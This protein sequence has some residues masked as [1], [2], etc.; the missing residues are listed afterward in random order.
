MKVYTVV[1]CLLCLSMFSMTSELYA[2]GRSDDG[3]DSLE[4]RGVIQ[5]KG[6]WSFSLH[7]RMSKSSFWVEMG[8]SLRGISAVEFDTEQQI[9]TVAFNGKHR[10]IGM[11]KPSSTSIRV[12]RSSTTSVLHEEGK[13]I[14]ISSAPLM[15]P[16]APP[17]MGR[18]PKSKP[19]AKAPKRPSMP[20]R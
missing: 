4:L 17:N 9:L 2:N 16:P 7:N 19:P 14:E 15:R 12:V 11:I 8:Q 5:L 18:P 13:K 10:E 1:F 20:D 3:L 6:K